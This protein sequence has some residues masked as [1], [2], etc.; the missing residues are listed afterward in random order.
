MINDPL[1]VPIHL[2]LCHC[3]FGEPQIAYM[4]AFAYNA[5]DR[6]DQTI[7]MLNLVGLPKVT[8]NENRTPEAIQATVVLADALIQVGQVNEARELANWTVE[9]TQLLFDTGFLSSWPRIL[10]ACSLAIP[11][12]A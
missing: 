5:T 1:C 11:L 6:F 2:N 7:E 3:R 9:F 4:L 10:G 8:L 12:F